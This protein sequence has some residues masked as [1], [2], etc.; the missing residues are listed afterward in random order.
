MIFDKPMNI[1]DEIYPDGIIIS[2][3][4]YCQER[5][6]KNRCIFKVLNNI[7][8]QDSINHRNYRS[9]WS[10]SGGISDKDGI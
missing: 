9:G 2:A 8:E 10:I 7:N 5:I 4:S 3:S 6:D 1:F